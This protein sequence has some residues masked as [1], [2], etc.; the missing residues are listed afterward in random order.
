MD[1][2]AMVADGVLFTVLC[3]QSAVLTQGADRPVAVEVASCLPSSVLM[4]FMGRLCQHLQDNFSEMQ[5]LVAAVLDS[6]LSEHALGM[7]PRCGPAGAAGGLLTSGGRTGGGMKRLAAST[8][9]S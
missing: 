2:K 5:P 3:W 1:W 8:I 6:H 9:T 4:T 7:D